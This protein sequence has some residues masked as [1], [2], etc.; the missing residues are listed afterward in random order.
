MHT[1][2]VQIERTHAN[3][4][5]YPWLEGQMNRTVFAPVTSLAAFHTFSLQQWANCDH[6]IPGGF[7]KYETNS[8]IFSGM[9]RVHNV[10]EIPAPF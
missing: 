8:T 7:F 6:M 10:L 4:A 9:K 3:V 5:L 2:F 1:N